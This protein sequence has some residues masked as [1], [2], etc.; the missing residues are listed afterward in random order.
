MHSYPMHLSPHVEPGPAAGVHVSHSRCRTGGA[1][2]TLASRQ[3]RRTGVEMLLFPFSDAGIAGARRCYFR[4]AISRSVIQFK[5]RADLDALRSATAPRP[6]S[7]VA[8]APPV[9]R[10]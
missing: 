6:S 4:V 1:E 9:F 2:C 5:T 3:D 8:S 7:S 10:E